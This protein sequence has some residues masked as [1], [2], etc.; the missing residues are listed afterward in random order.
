[1]QGSATLLSVFVWKSV[2]V[3]LTQSCPTLCNPMAVTLQAP[4]SMEFCR[5]EDWSGL[6]FL[7]LGHLPDPEIKPSLLHCGQIL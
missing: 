5:Q 6:P 1:M 3:S 7:P 4:L 2:F